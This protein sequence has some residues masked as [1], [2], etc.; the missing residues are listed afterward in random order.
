MRLLAI[1]IVFSF[2]AITN[3]ATAEENVLPNKV[4]E[5]VSRIKG[6]SPERDERVFAKM[7]GSSVASR[8]F[9]GCFATR[10]VRLGDQ[11]SLLP[12]IEFFDEEGREQNAFTRK[13]LAA[14]VG[15]SLRQ[16]LSGDPP[17]LLG[18]VSDLN[19]RYALLLFG[20]NDAMSEN[21]RVFAR[22]L[23]L[24]IRLLLAHGVVPILGSTTPRRRSKKDLWIRRFNVVVRALADVWSLPYIDYYTALSELPSLGLARDGVHPNVLGKGGLHNACVFEGRGLSF[25][26]NVRNLLTLKMLDSL[27]KIPPAS[28]SEFGSQR[29]FTTPGVEEVDAP[30]FSEWVSLKSD[31]AP[32]QTRIQCGK[33]T[34]EPYYLARLDV[35]SPTKYRVS[36][37]GMNGRKPRVA[38]VRVDENGQCRCIRS[39]IQTVERRLDPGEYEFWVQ[40]SRRSLLREDSVLFLVDSHL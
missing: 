33:R 28:N 12:A 6:A 34:V 8:A 13:S 21:E 5:H 37:L 24:A 18:E 16:V 7:G 11:T 15:W 40:P 26:Q 19:P 27:R 36:A 35:E 3:A 2:F 22:R 32:I 1:A 29:A 38:I 31:A 39:R 14:N 17:P 23:D 30:P 9:M 25:G 10:H 4:V 20:G